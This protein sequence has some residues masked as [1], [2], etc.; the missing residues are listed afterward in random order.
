MLLDLD[1]TDAGRSRWP[2]AGEIPLEAAAAAALAVRIAGDLVVDNLE[3]R[4]LVSGEVTASGDAECDRCLESFPVTFP[5]PVEILILRD[6]GM[7]DEA[8]ACT[9]HQKTGEVDLSGAL[10]ESVLLAWPQKLICREDCAGLCPHCGAN[11]ND[12]RCD[13]TVEETDPRWE[14]LP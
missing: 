14:G 4:V 11:R 9:I 1:R 5:V 7:E 13:C 3:S 6:T 10:R 8:D 2:V 12:E